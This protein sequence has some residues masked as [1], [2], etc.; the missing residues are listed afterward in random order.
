MQVV[1]GPGT[2]INSAVGEIQQQLQLRSQQTAQRAERAGARGAARRPRRRAARRPQQDKAAEGG[3]Q[4]V[5]YAELL[6]DL[7]QINLALRARPDR[8]AA[9]NDPNFVSALVF[10]PSRGA[11][12]AE[13]AL[14]LP[15]PERAARR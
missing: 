12:H 10:D 7:L 13:G 5:V 11:R 9:L 8:R 4:Q 2:F 6:R 15:V 14:R 1:Y 3:A